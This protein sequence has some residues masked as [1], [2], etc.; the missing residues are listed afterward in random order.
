MARHT[1]LHDD[2]AP[3]ERRAALGGNLGRHSGPV[4]GG[5]RPARRSSGPHRTIRNE[6]VDGVRRREPLRAVAEATAEANSASSPEPTRSGRLPSRVGLFGLT[7]RTPMLIL[8]MLDVLGLTLIVSAMAAAAETLGMV[9]AGAGTAS[10]ITVTLVLVAAA[11]ATGLYNGDIQYRER[12]L[13]GRCVVAFALLA[14]IAMLLL[15]ALTL[16][17]L[18]YPLPLLLATAGLAA[19]FTLGSRRA[20]RTLLPAQLFRRRILVLGAGREAA[21]IDQ[22]MRRQSDRLGFEI[23]AYVGHGSDTPAQVLAPAVIALESI[24]L[25][26]YCGQQRI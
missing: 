18:R 7:L 3:R 17:D 22:R 15:D 10:P 5:T 23:V 16:P 14:P 26:A 20:L 11:I 8:V 6:R 12:N 2:E 19:A 1:P 4:R 24:S 25:R 21:R 13:R 9:S